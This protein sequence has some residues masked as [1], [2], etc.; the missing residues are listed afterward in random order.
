MSEVKKNNAGT[1]IGLVLLG[2]VLLIFKSCIWGIHFSYGDGQ[3][4]GIVTNITKRGL[5][6]KT[7][8]GSM[9][10]GA[11]SADNSSMAGVASAR[12]WE[13]T[14]EDNKV[15]EILQEKERTR[16]PVTM[17]YKQ[18]WTGG[19]CNTETGYFVTGIK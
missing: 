3:R 6:C 2:L 19:V 13:F 7:W 15:A 18:Y 10:Y 5:M 17:T 9:S 11:F 8:E 12:T 14:V 1:I 4:T 16:Q